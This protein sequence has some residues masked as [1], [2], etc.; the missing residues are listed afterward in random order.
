MPDV[1]RWG[2]R[3]VGST[4]LCVLVAGALAAGG[5]RP[6]VASHDYDS[7]EPVPLGAFRGYLVKLDATMS[8]QWKSDDVEVVEEIAKPV[9]GNA[10]TAIPSG[11]RLEFRVAPAQASTWRPAAVPARAWE[12]VHR[13]RRI[14]EIARA[15]PLFGQPLLQ[16]NVLVPPGECDPAWQGQWDASPDDAAR[17]DRMW[18]LGA[19]HGANVVA[20][21]ELFEK[22]GRRPGDGVVVAHPDTGYLD[23]P[24]ILQA[25]LRPGFDFVDYRS[26]AFDR[27]EEGLLHRPGHGTR[28]A[29][30][31]VGQRDF[32][33]Y[34]DSPAWR[35]ISGVAYGAKLMPLRVANSVLLLDDIAPDMGHLAVSIHS[36]A[37][38]DPNFVRRPADV[39]SMSLG[40]IASRA[41]Q[42]ALL[43]AKARNVI[44][45]AAA[46]NNVPFGQ[47]VYP[48]RYEEVIAVAASNVHSQPWEGTA[49]GEA[50]VIS[51][52]GEDVWIASQK[53]GG[54]E[55]YNCVQTATGTSYAVATTAGVAALWLSY[56]A[57]EL[58]QVHDRAETFSALAK[59]TAR[60]VP[61]WNKA[62]H[63]PGILDARKLLDRWPPPQGNSRAASSRCEDLVALSALLPG[64]GPVVARELLFGRSGPQGEVCEA[65]GHLGDELAFL[66]VTDTRAAAA[67]AAFRERIDGQGALDAL[68][69]EILARPLSTTLRER[70]TAAG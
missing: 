14:P 22:S 11:I 70:L 53:G 43:M 1:C 62:E 5:E 33:V 39:I 27:T 23:H 38:G 24:M 59:A 35:R 48:A 67:L 30:V 55:R 12:T 69:Q 26:D 16:E 34:S 41:V 64:Q 56:R 68:R 13:L 63:G 17:K 9:L 50:V 49:R 52:P 45:L 4:L 21:W 2:W 58:D 40:G 8:R 25:I 47:V 44:V 36:A 32:S 3:V 31:I 60:A 7:A 29:S 57:E 61:G 6:M 19:A 37:I 46:G 54:D 18:S 28:T 20:A 51:A 15:E 66:F 42:D 10:W 65:V